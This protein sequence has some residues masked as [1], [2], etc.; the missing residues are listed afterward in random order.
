MK[1][2][3]TIRDAVALIVF[4]A[5]LCL[6][7]G[8]LPHTEL[9]KQ[10]IIEAIGVDYSNDMYEVSVQFFNMENSG[11][12]TLVDSSK[13]NVVI[14]KGR[15]T[16]IRSA[17]ES[18]SAK[19]GRPLMF[20]T[21]AAIVFGERAA[22]FDLAK[23]L[24]FAETYYQSNPKTLIAVAEGKASDIMDVRFKDG[25]V[26]VEHLRRVMVHAESLGLC[27]T[28]P[29]YRVMKE[30][31]QPTG[32]TVLPLLSVAETGSAA[33][34][35]GMAVE[36]S[37]GALLADRRL[38]AKLSLSDLSGL[39][40]LNDAIKNTSFLTNADG[41]N[42]TVSLYSAETKLEPRFDAGKLS[43][44]VKISALGKYI[45]SQL[46]DEGIPYSELV[47]QQC[48]NLIKERIS[49][50][51]LNAV[52][53][54]GTDPIGLSHVILSKDPMLWRELRGSFGELLKSADFAVEC[55]V[56]ID[57]FGVTH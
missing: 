24:S 36:I 4:G 14:V 3:K 8:C 41:R 25:A 39:Q 2:N 31:R 5:C 54:F 29:L 23:S 27:E 17:L 50:A 55:Q 33:T 45:D 10:A 44:A 34:E 42:I 16:E 9:D 46:Q 19:C 21:M 28:K 11:G 26:S 6:L 56:E 32:C 20:G 37:G 49:G 52:N 7:S 15:G 35:N 18:A 12:S 22:E 43:F 30:L 53:G 48:E 40:F 13:S 57:R 38:A 1:W 47:E 51:V